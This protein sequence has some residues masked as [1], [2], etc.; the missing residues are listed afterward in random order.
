[1]ISAPL[2]SLSYVQHWLVS[3]VLV[4]VSRFVAVLISKNQDIVIVKRDRIKLR[5]ECV[6][7]IMDLLSLRKKKLRII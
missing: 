7:S 4:A 6:N 5:R 3:N 1:M 2:S